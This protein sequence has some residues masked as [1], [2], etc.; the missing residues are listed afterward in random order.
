MLRPPRGI[1]TCGLIL[2]LTGL[3]WSAELIVDKK[4]PAADDKNAGALESPLRTIQA[5][6][7]KAQPG[8]SVLVRGVYHEGVHFKHSGTCPGDGRIHPAIR[9]T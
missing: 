6:V 5:A 9:A 7:D 2:I 4:N 3:A 8:D 1:M